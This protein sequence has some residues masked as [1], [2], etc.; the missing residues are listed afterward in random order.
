MS[1]EVNSNNTVYPSE[2]TVKCMRRI[3]HKI[4]WSHELKVPSCSVR[5]IISKEDSTSTPLTVLKLLF[6]DHGMWFQ[7]PKLSFLE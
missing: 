4:A 3:D 5:A 6:V 2:R 7:C 1:G